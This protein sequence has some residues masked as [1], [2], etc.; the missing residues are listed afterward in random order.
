MDK[1]NEQTLA[2]SPLTFTPHQRKLQER[3]TNVPQVAKSFKPGMVTKVAGKD[4]ASA[5]A[6]QLNA[7]WLDD[8]LRDASACAVML[9][10]RTE[11]VQSLEKELDASQAAHEEL[12]TL[13]QKSME[14]ERDK[15]RRC[16]Q[17]QLDLEEWKEKYKKLYED[18]KSKISLSAEKIQHYK[19]QLKASEQKQQQ[20]VD[21]A[22]QLEALTKDTSER[23]RELERRA[24]D[25]A[26]RQIQ[27]ELQQ[28]RAEAD[29]AKRAAMKQRLQLQKL[30]VQAKAR[31]SEVV[32]LQDA[33]QQAKRETEQ[34]K[35]K[36][37]RSPGKASGLAAPR[38][39][40]GSAGG[41]AS[42]R[43]S[44]AGFMSP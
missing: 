26:Q 31:D 36:A 9:Q 20:F 4:E 11:R 18:A 30:E 10:D 40:T 21:Q 13:L 28:A 42:G 25:K 24:L 38:L 22:M 29:E 23:Q 17:Q 33:L 41:S 2:L 1:E 7:S 8:L 5:L 43:F 19:D 44:L 27:A 35:K 12:S 15:A 34:W 6:A 39:S 32:E 14:R 37:E 16:E 3:N